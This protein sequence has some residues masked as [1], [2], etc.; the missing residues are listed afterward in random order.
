MGLDAAIGNDEAA[1]VGQRQDV[2]R[3]DAAGPELA[4]ALRPLAAEV[5]DADHAAVRD[6]IVFRR[7]G[8]AAIGRKGAMAVEVPARH[9]FEHDR[10]ALTFHIE[11]DGEGAGATGKGEAAPAER[12][13]RNIMAAAGKR[14][15]LSVDAIEPGYDDAVAAVG[16]APRGGEERVVRD[17]GFAGTQ[18]LRPEGQCR[19]RSTASDK[20]GPSVNRRPEH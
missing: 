1:P 9:C 6:V 7:I 12:A 13:D 17:A 16:L 3:A 14:D 20:Q 15:H 2:V 4:D 5:V 10:R 8:Q 11:A 18:P 19:Q